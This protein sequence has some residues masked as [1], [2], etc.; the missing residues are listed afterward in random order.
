MGNCTHAR[1]AADGQIGTA[2]AIGRVVAPERL[3]K[4]LKELDR[5]AYRDEWT[6]GVDG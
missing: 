3:T 1:P 6:L 2:P 5:S 4:E